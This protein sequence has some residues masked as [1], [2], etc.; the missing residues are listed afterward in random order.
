M[1][2]SRLASSQRAVSAVIVAGWL[3]C[4]SQPANSER[5]QPQSN[6]TSPDAPCANF[7]NLRNPVWRDIGVKID[8]A[9]PW[10][11]GFRRAL[12]FWNTVLTANLRE[13][14]D[15]S[16]CS[17]R[18]IDGN[19]GILDLAV[20]A[21]SQMTDRANFRGK[22]A[23]S[24][25]AAKGMNSG[26]IYA[27][28]IHEIGHMLGLKHNANIHSVM[29]FLDVEGSEVLDSRDISDLSRRHELRP[30]IFASD[31]VPIQESSRK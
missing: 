3:V 1:W 27:A 30:A 11:D 2:I 8:A 29:Y 12:R 23:V 28:A 22:I 24:S 5:Q 16:V 6:W 7:D 4:A 15:L 14:P 31:F 10:A 19:P 25:V 18:I 17:I 21:R 13:E 9:R 26:E 20:A